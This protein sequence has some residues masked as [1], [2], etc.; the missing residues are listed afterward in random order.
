MF[1][2]VES[3]SLQAV[4]F[5]S[6]EAFLAYFEAGSVPL[7]QPTCIVLDYEMPGAD[8]L[9]LQQMLREAGCET[10]VIVVSGRVD[11]QRAVSVMQAGAV[12]LLQKPYKA[13]ELE[14]HIR[15]CLKSNAQLLKDREAEKELASK[16]DT[17]DA[18]EQKV[19]QAIVEGLANKQIARRLDIGLRTVELRRANILK[20]LGVRSIPEV[21]RM[22]T[23]HESKQKPT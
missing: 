14:D 18:K 5:A 9:A 13:N 16:F 11:V 2:L 12:T 17:L 15:D 20:K 4:E 22:V 1:A 8:G 23:L 7:N 6:A 19:L 21:V 3:I 10:P